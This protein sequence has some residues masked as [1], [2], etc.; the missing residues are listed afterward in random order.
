M[1]LQ[2]VRL[3]LPVEF[4]KRFLKHLQNS[5]TQKE[6]YLKTEKEYRSV[7]NENKYSNFDSYRI[8]R[9]VRLKRRLSRN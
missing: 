5:Q 8:A 6:A 1:D 4:D 3:A 2:D 9:Y 7:Y